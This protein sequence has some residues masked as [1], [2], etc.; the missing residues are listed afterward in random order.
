MKKV[1][2]LAHKTTQNHVGMTKVSRDVFVHDIII[3]DV[4][5][6]DYDITRLNAKLGNWITH[7]IEVDDKERL[8]DVL[9]QM[10]ADSSWREDDRRLAVQAAFRVLPERVYA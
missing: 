3:C 10:C 1:T 2:V 4:V 8:E 6:G 9:E 5:I 7:E